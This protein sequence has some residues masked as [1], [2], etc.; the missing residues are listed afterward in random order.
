[1]G[2][3]TNSLRCRS[4]PVCL[5]IVNQES[6]VAYEA[7]YTSMEGGVFEFA[8]NLKLCSKNCEMCDAVR[9]QI[10]QGPMQNVLTPPSSHEYLVHHYAIHEFAEQDRLGPSKED[11]SGGVS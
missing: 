5:A 10:E 2:M 9:E 6:A 4:N 11:D 1:M 8:H 3:T 7:M